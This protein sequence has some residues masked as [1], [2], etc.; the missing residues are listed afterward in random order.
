MDQANAVTKGAGP[1][2]RQVE[3]PEL[4][5]DLATPGRA[6]HAAVAVDRPRLTQQLV[7]VR[8]TFPDVD[9]T[10]SGVLKIRQPDQ[11][12]F[13]GRMLAGIRSP[14]ATC[15]SRGPRIVRP[16]RRTETPLRRRITSRC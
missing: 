3:T 1:T 2:A 15:Q 5:L 14:D 16:A 4:A 6:Y 8:E 7:S 12:L 9:G 10:T 13:Y 11:F